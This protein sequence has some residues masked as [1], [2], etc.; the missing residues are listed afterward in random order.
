MFLAYVE[1]ACVTR[2][3]VLFL[4][5]FITDA[6]V[7]RAVCNL[8]GSFA[9]DRLHSVDSFLHQPLVH[10]PDHVQLTPVFGQRIL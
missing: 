10:L 7:G 1:T 4:I 6:H 8:P 2:R 5:Y 3:T 9:V